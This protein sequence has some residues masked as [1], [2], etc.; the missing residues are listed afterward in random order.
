MGRLVLN[1][2]E[3]RPERARVDF[4]DRVFPCAA[5]ELGRPAVLSQVGWVVR[6]RRHPFAGR[7]RVVRGRRLVQKLPSDDV[8]AALREYSK[9]ILAKKGE[10]SDE[11]ESRVFL[12]MRVLFDLPQSAPAASRRIHKGWTNWPAPDKDDQVT[13]A[14]PISWHLRKPELVAPRAG[15]RGMPYDA[16]NEYRSF[17]KQYLFRDL[18]RIRY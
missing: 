2:L 14:W 15:S 18:K 16:E 7:H 8:V 11:D 4:P 3:F 6:R 5:L 12:L 17:L 1:V 9:R 13:M 10:F